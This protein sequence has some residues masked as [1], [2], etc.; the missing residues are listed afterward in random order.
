MTILLT[1]PMPHQREEEIFA[2]VRARGSWWDPGTGKSRGFLGHLDRLNDLQ[3]IDSVVILAPK[4]VHSNWTRHELPK[5]VASGALVSHA[6]S[7][8]DAGKSKHDDAAR[9]LLDASEKRPSF[10]AISYDSM[11]TDE[12]HD[13]LRKLVKAKP[14]LLLGVDEVQRI[15][16]PGA[17]RSMRT[18]AL[19]KKAHFSRAMTASLVDNSPFDAYNPLRVLDPEAWHGIGCDNFAAFKAYFGVWEQVQRGPRSYPAL[20]KY[21]NEKELQALI[22]KYGRR[23]EKADVLNLPEKRRARVYFK[24]ERAQRKVYDDLKAQLFTILEDGSMV[25]CQQRI[26]LMTR[27][28]QV[29]AGYVPDDD[30]RRLRFLCDPNPRV[31]LT[32][33]TV[34]DYPGQKLIFSRF[35]PDVDALLVEL[36]KRK[37]TAVRY[38]GLV[39]DKDRVDALVAFETGAAEYFVSKPECGGVGLNL[40]QAENVS[41]HTCGFSYEGRRQSEDRAHRYGQDKVVGYTDT[42]AEDSIDEYV[43]AK[44]NKKKSVSA[45]LMGD[46]DLSLI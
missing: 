34:E 46:S 42:L 26:V 28:S 37:K 22:A 13:F 32:I 14:R 30:E 43:M 36:K 25:S 39:N 5:H 1:E 17:K 18:M 29:A 23:I 41:Y 16:T 24:M 7:T 44:L 3:A 6:W 2:S 4:G 27:L 8:D 33:D 15:K 38:D 31:K 20:T 35:T 10:L 12:G 19:S 11:M 9:K 21:R 45:D 40:V